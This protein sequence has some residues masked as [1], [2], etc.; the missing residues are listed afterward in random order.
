MVAGDFTLAVA[1]VLIVFMIVYVH[2]SSSFLACVTMYQ[3]IM[4]LPVGAL[5]YRRLFLIDFF[6]FVHI[7]VVYL[8]LG[9]GADDVFVLVDTFRHLSDEHLPADGGLH[10]DEELAALLQ[11]TLVRSGQAIFSTSFTTTVAFLSQSVSDI[12]PLRTCGYYAATCIIMNYLFTMLF[13]PSALIIYHKRLEG[14]RCCCPS[15]TLRQEPLPGGERVGRRS[16][17]LAKDGCM[18]WLLETIYIPAMRKQVCG[19]RVF[20]LGVVAV[21]MATAAQ[22]FCFALQLTPPTKAETWLPKDHMHWGV[23]EFWSNHFYEGGH[24]GYSVITF[25]W[26]IEGADTAGFEPYRPSKNPPTAKFDPSFDITTAEAQAEILDVCAKMQ[27]LA[28][29]LEGCEGYGHTLMMSSTSKAYSCFLEDMQQYRV[30]VMGRPSSEPLPTGAGFLEELQQFVQADPSVQ[31]SSK[32]CRAD[33]GYD[34]GFIDGQL[35]YVSVKLRSRLALSTPYSSGI[36]VRD[37]IQ[38]F[39]RGRQGGAPSGLKS[40]RFNAGGMFSFYDSAAQMVM[41]LFSGISIA[42]PLAFVALLVSTRNWIVSVYAVSCV[43]GIV[44]CVLGF[45]KS[46]MGWGLGI[47]EAVAGVIVIGYSVDYVVH[48]AHV[49]CEASKKGHQTRDARATFAVRNMGSTIFAGA[50]TTAGSAFVMF[51]CG[52]FH[53]LQ[54]DGDADL[55]HDHVLVLVLDGALHRPSMANRPAGNMW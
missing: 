22:G 24:A 12:M 45:C 21:M 30:D 8:V 31:Y 15:P 33:Y 14:K 20:A 35:K 48:L 7:L 47:A 53:V 46:A 5:F 11:S 41:A 6:D 44:A 10:S 37:M 54:Q 52:G 17:S 40:M 9:I 55:H 25:T 38:D 18:K 49:Y 26:G 13:T 27:T 51:F 28:C 3:I 4:S 29:D 16:K 43:G 32:V 36:E 2:V 34:V 1:A 23:S 42:F 50:V 19:V 39:V